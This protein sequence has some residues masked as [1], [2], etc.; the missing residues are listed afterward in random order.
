VD[1]VD[2]QSIVDLFRAV[3][4]GP[5]VVIS[6]I[7]LALAIVAVLI[8][9]SDTRVNRINANSWETY[10]MYNSAE[11][12]EARRVARAVGRDPA[13]EQVKSYKQYAV[14][15]RLDAPLGDPPNTDLQ[16]LRE[17]EQ[18]LHYLLNYYHQLGTL[19]RKRLLDKD[20][21][22][23][24]VGGGLH[25][26]WEVLGRIPLFFDDYP[27]SGMYY[28]YEAYEDWHKRRYPKLI[29][30]ARKAR[31]MVAEQLGVGDPSLG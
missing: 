25:D 31:S 15:F 3:P 21:T 4:S 5:T 20:F 10:R 1:S 11:I 9:T 16:V 18:A 22:M 30:K 8:T 27:Y 29:K 26:R 19:L 23:F 2:V 24:L 12:I 13:W 28:L 14:F 17:Q 6:L 7:S